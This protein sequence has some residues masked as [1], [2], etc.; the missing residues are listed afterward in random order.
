LKAASTPNGEL[1]VSI[2]NISLDPIDE[3][4]LVVNRE[5]RRIE[6]LCPDGSY[7]S[8]KFSSDGNKL[9]LDASADI[10]TPVIL[11]MR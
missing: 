11:I 6:A 8:V 3:I 1:F 9:T 10:L 7:K 2:I 5:I 4:T